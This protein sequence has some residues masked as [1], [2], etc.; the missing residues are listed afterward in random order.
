MIAQKRSESDSTAFTG[1]YPPRLLTLP[2]NFRLS[3]LEGV[4][5][6]TGGSPNRGYNRPW[7]SAL[8][9]LSKAC[10]SMRRARSSSSF[11]RSWRRT[12][13]TLFSTRACFWG[14]G[15]WSPNLATMRGM[16]GSGL[17]RKRGFRACF[18]SWVKG[19]G[20]TEQEGGRPTW[21]PCGGC[22]GR[23]CMENDVLGAGLRAGLRARKHK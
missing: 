14:A 4:R 20:T 21:R 6:G 16:R 2:I 13:S 12:R 8:P 7:L 22:G 15:R 10:S 9:H 23:A 11:G 1:L 19:S 18:K 17:H 3:T 5:A